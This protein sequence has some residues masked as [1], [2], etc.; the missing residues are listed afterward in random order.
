MLDRSK[1]VSTTTRRKRTIYNYELP[2]KSQLEFFGK[3]DQKSDFPIGSNVR[4]LVAINE[5]RSPNMV[6][7][8]LGVVVEHDKDW[9]V[10]GFAKPFKD[11]DG[12]IWLFDAWNPDRNWTRIRYEA[13]ELELMD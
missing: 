13:K 8:S 7:G 10:V 12:T 3:S 11:G 9:V 6:E 4:T 2:R 5:T 1:L